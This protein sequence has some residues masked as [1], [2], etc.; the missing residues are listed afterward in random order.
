MISGLAY[1]AIAKATMGVDVDRGGYVIHA[2]VIGK[3][4]PMVAL[5][6][7]PGFSGNAVWGVGYGLKDS[8][9][10]YLFDQLGTGKSRT[11]GTG[12]FISLERTVSDIE[13]LR[14]RVGA[15]KW[16][17]FGQSWGVIVALNYAA[18]HPSAVDHLVLTSVPGLDLDGFV[19]QSNLSKIIPGSV[20]ADLARAT[21]VEASVLGVLPFYFY[22]PSIGQEMAKSTPPR[23]FSVQPYLALQK[24]VL[25]TEKYRSTLA[26]LKGKRF[27][28]TMIQGHQDPCG[29]A[30]PALLRER[31]LPL[32]KIKM[33]DRCG[34]FPWLEQSLD[35]FHEMH[36]ALQL[37]KPAYLREDEHRTATKAW[38]EAR[39][40]AGWPFGVVEK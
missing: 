3:G 37:P 32:A 6:G 29:A 27:P 15:K 21:T 10:T 7:G 17:V 23:L 13:A 30:M 40:K 31:Y 12:D 14:L 33:I 25:S 9:K 20:Q 8:V 11:K 16:V 26:L 28:V 39:E 2:S 4:R 18:R 1:L 5:A 24:H 34:H 36:D 22:E 19:L 38:F 35:F